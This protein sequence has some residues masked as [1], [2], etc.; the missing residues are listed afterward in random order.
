MAQA[1]T[2]VQGSVILSGDI[3]GSNDAYNPTLGPTGVVP[4]AN[5]VS[6]VLAVDAK[7]RITDWRAVTSTEWR[8]SIPS[9]TTTSLGLAYASDTTWFGLNSGVLSVNTT[10]NDATAL[11]KGFV[12]VGSGLAVNNGLVSVIYSAVTNLVT[13]ATTTS[14]GIVEVGSGILASNGVLSID[15]GPINSYSGYPVAD[16]TT[17][18]VFQVGTGLTISSGTLSLPDATSTT[19][20]VLQLSTN[21]GLAATNGLLAAQYA[22][23]TRLG[24]ASIGS[25]LTISSGTLSLDASQ[26]IA[27]TTS[28]GIVQ[29]GSGLLIDG[30]GYLIPDSGTINLGLQN[31]TTSL[32][33]IAAYSTGLTISSGIVSTTATTIINTDLITATTA[34]KGV[35][36]ISS[37]SGSGL[38]IASGI[39]NGAD[40]S[41]SKIGMVQVSTG[42]GLSIT[43][44]T[45]SG[46]DAT[47]AVKGMVKLSTVNGLSVSSG[48]ING[49]NASS[50]VKGMVS[51]N[52]APSGGYFLSIASGVL[53]LNNSTPSDAT[54]SSPG[55]VQIDTSNGLA[56]FGNAVNGATAGNG[57]KGMVQVGSS[58]TVS[59]GILYATAATT[60][61]KGFVQVG[62]GIDVN[63]GVL[64]LQTATNTTLGA[65]TTNSTNITS[66]AGVIDL[67]PIVAHGSRANTWTAP[68]VENLDTIT[69]SASTVIDASLGNAFYISITQ[70]TTISLINTTPGQAISIV[71]VQ[72]SGSLVSFGSEFKFNIVGTRSLTVG[73]ICKYDIIIQ[74]SAT[75]LTGFADSFS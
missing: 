37:S 12:E 70:P 22:T 63:S 20:G 69:C 16:V 42:T 36:S 34:A 40:A 71:T 62:T 43:S 59:T 24:T 29:V 45:L 57:N 64:S 19:K 51:I 73:A 58:F 27:T 2:T 65:V 48:I 75:L 33:G 10:T 18:G 60:G 56:F 41:T 35:I 4:S 3:S 13:D 50:S 53:T 32:K 54:T 38:S 17:K 6:P 39:L 52:S 9:A 1:T 11:C 8:D 67:A 31:A 55:I 68:Q 14:K 25:N 61:T 72:S 49:I 23:G 66:S 74:N 46:V 21:A 44:G 30:G 47:T 5:I 26:L 28:K 7:G 15:M